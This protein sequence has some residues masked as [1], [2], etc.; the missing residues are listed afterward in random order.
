M[1][2]TPYTSIAKGIKCGTDKGILFRNKKKQ[3][4]DTC[5]MNEP[6]KHVC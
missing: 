5:Y 3:S 1:E 2:T 6:Q 4:A